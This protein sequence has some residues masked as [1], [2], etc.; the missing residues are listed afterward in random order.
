VSLSIWYRLMLMVVNLNLGWLSEI[1]QMSLKV[2][3][4]DF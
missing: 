1:M 2:E 3:W 4:A